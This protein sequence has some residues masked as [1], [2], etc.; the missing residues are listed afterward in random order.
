M[1]WHHDA[2]DA[3]CADAAQAQALDLDP[4]LREAALGDQ[5]GLALAEVADPAG[6]ADALGADA[7]AAQPWLSAL[8]EP[9]A[10]PSS[11]PSPPE[12]APE[13]ARVFGVQVLARGHF[14]AVDAR[15]E[16]SEQF[17]EGWTGGLFF[18]QASFL[19]HTLRALSPTPAICT[20]V[21]RAAR[22][23]FSHTI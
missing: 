19:S 8:V 23:F 12:C 22:L 1:T 11:D 20:C 21:G 15:G 6:A 14:S 2:D 16:R 5:A 9:S 18:T 7:Q 13:L 4:A 3:A 17:T 10:A